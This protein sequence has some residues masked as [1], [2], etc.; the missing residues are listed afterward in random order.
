M[1]KT[2]F[3]V[4]SVIATDGTAMPVRTGVSRPA[5]WRILEIHKIIRAGRYPNCSSLAKEIEVTRK[6]IQRD[7]SFLRE[8]WGLPLEYDAER[9]GYHYTQEVHEFPMLHLSR[10]DLVALFLARHALEPLRGTGLERML[11]A[12]FSKIAEACP[13]EVS[14]QWH[15]LDGAFSVK[16]MGVLAA[17]VRLFS[18]LLDAVMARREVAFDYCKLT[19]SKAE[20][21][22]V[23]PYHVGQ[24]EH[25]WY[26]LAYDPGRQGMRTFALQ[27][28]TNLEM[29][30]TTF[31]RDARFD[32]SDHLGGGFGVWSYEGQE[33]GPHAVRI[34]FEG[35]AA[36]V[37]AERSWHPSQE[38]KELDKDGDVIEFHATLSGLEEVTRWVL[39]W[40]SKAKVL[41][42][43]ELKRR[44]REELVKMMADGA[45]P[46]WQAGVPASL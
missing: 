32:V 27:R 6:T 31:V 7:V 24:I 18:D 21:R 35:Y 30:G 42:P 11:A 25:G 19:A 44:V 15:E 26:V 37:V 9:N 29:L 10:N 22:T 38:I 28:M 8:Q 3:P 45:E 20:R 4:K 13:G 41:G 23:Q 14:I 43:P 46:P 5:L 40:G 16:A 33:G 12:S 34:R 2:L 36:R 1:S 17:D 39:S